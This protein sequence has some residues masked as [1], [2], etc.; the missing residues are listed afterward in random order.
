MSALAA[1]GHD[2][3]VSGSYDRTLKVWD[4]NTGQAVMTLVGHVGRVNTVAVLDARRVMSGSD[5]QTLRVWN[6]E[7]GRCVATVPLDGNLTSL[8]VT[9]GIYVRSYGRQGRDGLCIAICPRRIDQTDGHPGIGFR[10]H[11][12]RAVGAS[13]WTGSWTGRV[14]LGEQS[15]WA[16]RRIPWVTG[17]HG[18]TGGVAAFVPAERTSEL[19]SHSKPE[20]VMFASAVVSSCIWLVFVCSGDE[21]FRWTVCQ[22][23]WYGPSRRSYPPR[24]LLRTNAWMGFVGT[25]ANRQQYFD[26][27][28]RISQTNFQTAGVSVDALTSLIQS[29]GMGDSVDHGSAREH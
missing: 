5:D 14:A 29:C 10:G 13:Q 8:A 7:T 12:T 18:K 17:F 11:Q 23:R 9:T 3:L 22:G 25:T 26:S 6:L 24:T 21:R 4:R 16:T 19:G 27:R 15:P 20:T 2:R 28:K 1:L